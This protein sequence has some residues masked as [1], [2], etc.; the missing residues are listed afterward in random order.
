[1]KKKDRLPVQY[2]LPLLLFRKKKPVDDEKKITPSASHAVLPPDESD[3]G[4]FNR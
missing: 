4:H 2:L 3:A 1:L